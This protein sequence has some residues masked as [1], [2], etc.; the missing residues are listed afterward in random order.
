M[1]TAQHK[2]C[3]GTMFPDPPHDPNDRRMAGPTA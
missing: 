3:Y 1:N 2:P